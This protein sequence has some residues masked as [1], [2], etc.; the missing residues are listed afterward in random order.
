MHHP[1]LP[2]QQQQFEA[3]PAQVV[4]TQADIALDR[5]RGLQHA[6]EHAIAQDRC[7]HRDQGFAA[8]DPRAIR[9]RHMRLP[10]VARRAEPFAIRDLFGGDR[11]R[12]PVRGTRGDDPALAIRGQCTQHRR[13]G[14]Q[15][16]LQLDIDR[17]CGQHRAVG[18]QLDAGQLSLQEI[19]D[20]VRAE[21]R[22]GA[23]AQ[24]HIALVA[25]PLVPKQCHAEHQRRQQRGE[26]QHAGQF[27]A[28]A[29]LRARRGRRHGPLRYSRQGETT[30]C[31][32]QKREA[33]HRRGFGSGCDATAITSP[34]PP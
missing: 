27:V 2:I 13:I 8:V 1:I 10:A 25:L 12:A 23:Q 24:A 9:I 5:D 28:Q 21:L 18:H 29:P 6:I 30:R 14:A 15:Q 26:D 11:D 20:R 16:L 33:P 19:V 32:V 7:G 34:R 3:A 31:G 17:L 22:V 4:R